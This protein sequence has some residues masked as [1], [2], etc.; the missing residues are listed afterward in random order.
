MNL[1][2]FL[3]IPDQSRA[4]NLSGFGFIYLMNLDAF[5]DISDQL[6]AGNPSRFGFIYIGYPII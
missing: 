4:G 1:D 2:A 5:L 6:R 3:D